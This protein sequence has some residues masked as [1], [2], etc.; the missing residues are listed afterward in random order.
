MLQHSTVV[1]EFILIYC[2][3]VCL[4]ILLQLFTDNN[5]WFRPYLAFPFAVIFCQSVQYFRRQLHFFNCTFFSAN[6]LLFNCFGISKCTTNTVYYWSGKQKIIDN[7]VSIIICK[8]SA[9]FSLAHMILC[10]MEAKSEWLLLNLKG[11]EHSLHAFTHLQTYIIFI[12]FNICKAP[13]V[14][15]FV[16]HWPFNLYWQHW[17]IA[18]ISWISPS[19]CEGTKF[20][21]HIGDHTTNLSIKLFFPRFANCICVFAKWS[22]HKC[23]INIFWWAQLAASERMYYCK[24][25]QQVFAAVVI[26]IP[27][28]TLLFC[29]DC[30]LLHAN[31]CL[32]SCLATS[33]CHCGKLA[34]LGLMYLATFA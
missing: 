14:P 10:W 6:W 15:L 19:D 32:C 29:F 8:Q 21:C 26:N 22:C 13:F 4:R 18:K 17:S 7:N 9:E 23:K 1:C 31:G 30:S 20:A 2:F 12:C 33:C 16:T 3:S 11:P 24:H 27:H 34:W 28:F 5:M 25:L